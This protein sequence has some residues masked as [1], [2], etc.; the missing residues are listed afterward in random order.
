MKWAYRQLYNF[1]MTIPQ[2]QPIIE[3]PLEAIAETVEEHVIVDDRKFLISRPA[4]ADTLLDH[5][6]VRARFSDGAYLPYWVDLWPSARMLG[7]VL[8]REHWTPGMRVLEIGC[9][10]GLPGVVALS[11]GLRV[12]FSDCDRSA[13][14]F[15]GRN[16]RANGFSDFELLPLDWNHPP[17][18]LKFPLVFGSDLIYEG[19]NVA[20]LVDLIGCV[21]APDGVCLITD[22]D[23]IPAELLR[24]TLEAHGLRFTTRVV[25]AGEPG[26]RRSRGTLYRITRQ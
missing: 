1:N 11:V 18:D 4:K 6:A 22:Q 10:L 3:T 12:T 17:R 5:P 19:R 23:R 21:L 20:P 26:G 7:K 14:H 8:L 25:H 15:A 9:G 16:A 2:D 24:R 13:L